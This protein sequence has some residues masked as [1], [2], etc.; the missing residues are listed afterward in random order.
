MNLRSNTT[1]GFLKLLK[2]FFPAGIVSGEDT[3]D[4]PLTAELFNSD[5]MARHS[6]A[7][8]TT[9]VV[10]KKRVKDKLLL[11]LADNEMVLLEV[12][13]LLT[14]S[15]KES[16]LITPAGEW[17]LDNF[18]LLEE[19][20]RTAKKH[21]PKEYSEGLPQLMNG[22][23]A[24]LPR[25]YDIALEIISHS[26]GRID[27][28][29]LNNFVGAYQTVTPFFLGE[30][31]AVPIMLRL[32]L[33]ENLRRVCGQ[34]AIDRINRFLADYWAKRM[35]TA[36]ENEPKSLVLEIADMAR[37]NPPVDRAFV[38]EFTR[39]LRGKGRLLAQPLIWVEE[40]LAEAGQTSNELVQSENQK[41]AAD[42]VSVSNSIGSLRLL[43]D[44]DWK[45]F[46]ENNSVVEHKLLEDGIYALMDFS[47]RDHYRHVVEHI[48]KKSKLQ[49][50]EVAQIA[51]DLTKESAAKN[52]DDDRT[53]HLGYF[54]ISDGLP[55][56]E[57]RAKMHLN[58][59][60]RIERVLAGFPLTLYLGAILLISLSI[61]S[62]IVYKAY[63]DGNSI[64]LIIAFAIISLICASQLAVALVN[65]FTTLIAGPGLLPRMD[66]SI[67]IPKDSKTMVVIPTMLTGTDEIDDLVEALEVRFLANR[68]ENLHFALLTDF[69][70]AHERE[71]PEDEPLLQ[72]AVQK[73]TELNSKY[74][75]EKEDLFFLFQRPRKWN[76]GDNIWMGY[77][78]KRGKLGDLNGFF[79]GNSKDCFS[80]ILGDQDI[81]PQ[82][83]YVI[84]LDSDT[85]LPRESA[86]KI[87]GTMAHPL[88]RAVYSETKRRVVE[89]YGILQPRVS[90]S[91]PGTDST[92]FARMNG[93]EPG[94][95]PYTRATSDVYQDLFAE[96]SFIGKGIYEVDIF[97]KV[98]KGQFPENRI[99]SHDLLEGCYV[100]AGLLSDVQ[101]YEKHPIR[102]NAD[103]QR[104]SRWIRGDWQIAAWFLPFVPGGDKHWHRNPLSALSRWKIFDNIRRSLVPLAFT[105][106][107]LL[108]WTIKDFDAAWTLIIT[109]LIIFPVVLSSVWDLMRK[110]KDLILS[111][112]II[113]SGRS[114]GN[115]A[116][117][118]LFTMICLPYEAYK[119]VD[120]I[121]RVSW[122]MLFSHKHLLDWVT[123]GKIERTKTKGLV[124]SYLD[125]WIEPLV[126]V[127][128]F[129]C[130]IVLSQNTLRS[131]SPILLLWLIAPFI[132]W[133]VSKP[134]ARQTAKLS[135]TAIIYL[136]KLSRKTWSFFE[137]F[138]T[139]IENWLPPDNFQEIP[140]PVIAH[141]TSPTNMGLSLL[142]NLAAYD[143]GYLTTSEFM[144]RTTGAL[145]TMQKMERFKGHFYNW[146]DTLSLAP[147]FPRYIST[148]DSGN[149]A[150]H[151]LTL[152]QGILAMLNQPVIGPQVLKGLRDTLYVLIDVADKSDLIPLNKFKTD[153][154][155]L[156]IVEPDSLPEMYKCLQ[157]LQSNFKFIQNGLNAQPQTEKYRWAAALAR[158][159]QKHVD[160]IQELAPWL[161]LKEAPSGLRFISTLHC[162]PGLNELLSYCADVEVE[163]QQQQNSHN[164]MAQ[165]E[166][167]QAFQLSVTS[168]TASV[169]QKIASLNALALQCIG[170]SELDYDF[171]YSRTKKLLSIGYNVEEHRPDISFYDLLGSEAR[172]STFV[173]IAQGK[174]PQESWFSLGRLL[175]NAGGR[176]ILLSWSGSMFEY[177]MPLLIMPSYENTLLSQTD[178]A[179]VARQIDYGKIRNVPW[180]ISESCY[181]TFDAALSYQ[182][183]AFGVPG[184][185]LKRGL[186]EDLVIAPYA[187]AL[188]LMLKPEHA[189]ENL[190][191]MSDSGF[192][193]K[194][195]FYE[196]IDYTPSRLT[197]GQT[198]AVVQSYMAHHQG[199]S[200]L[201][202]A[203]LLLNQPMQKRFTAEPQFQATLLLLQERIPK[204]TSLFAHTS[205]I[206]E[207]VITINEPHARIITSP[208]TTVPEVQLLSNGKYHVMV[209]NSGGGYS[210]W[211]DIAVTRWREDATRDNWGTFCYIR[212]LDNGTYWSTSFQPT[213][214]K[215]EN[216]EMAF[217]QGRADFKSSKNKLDIHT[218]IVVSPE[219]DIEMRR[220]HICNNS[221]KVRT[222]DITSYAEVVIAPAAADTTHPA[223]SNLF[224][225]T[226]IL[227]HKNA[228]ICTRRP[229]SVNE[230]QPWMLHLMNIHGK[231]TA[232]VSYETDRME[233][234]G[235]GNTAAN[236]QAMRAGGLLSGSQGSVLDPIVAIRHKIVLEPDETIVIDVITGMGETRD[237]CQML[238]DKYQDKHHKD[239]V[240]E[241]AWTHNQVVLRQINA[242]ESE[243][244]LYTRLANSVLF[245]NP[246]LRAE[247]G[248]LIRNHKGQA[249]LWPYS[250]SGDLPV[251]LLKIEEPTAIDLV[252]QLIAAHTF[253]RLKGLS[254]D[255]IIWNDSHDGYR[256]VLQNQ[257][258]GLIGAQLIDKPGGIFIRNSEQISNEDR[259]LFQTVA[260]VIINSNGGSL[261]DHI[262]R[263][264]FPKAVIQNLV[265]TQAY[266]PSSSPV[267]LPAGLVLFNGTGGFSTDG[268]EYVISS[269]SEKRTPA[270]WVN[271]IANPGFGTVISES[272]QSY[273]WHENAH[274]LR[275]T[276]WEN[277]AVSDLG[278]EVFYLRD[279]ETG[280]FWSPT[281]LPVSSSTAYI[282]RHG[283]G[284]SVFEHEEAGIY[285]EMW[286]YVDTEAA[287]KFTAIKLKNKSGKPRRITVTG[288]TEWVLGEMRG[289]TAMHIATEQDPETGALFARNPYNT[290][291]G[292]RVAFF[293]TDG[294]NETFTADR[295]EFIGRNSSLKRPAAMLRTKLSGKIG[296]GLDPCAAIQVTIELS[297]GRE[298]EII[299]KL[300]EGTD[301]QD[302]ANLVRK[303]KGTENAHEALNR[304]VSYWKQSVEALQV[305]TPDKSVDLL[306][307]GW[308]TYQTL[309]CRLWARSGFYQSGGAFGFRDQLQDVI[310]LIHTAPQL[311]RKHIL[312]AASHQFNE[313]DVLHWWH[314]PMGK[315]V[316]TRCSDDYLWLPFVTSG[317]I[318]R[319]GDT[320]ILDEW[321]PFLDGRLLNPGED[322]YYDLFNKS[323]RTAILYNHCVRAIKHGLNFGSHGLPLMGDGDWNDGMD[324]VG[325]QG[326]GE[327]VWLAFFLYDILIKFIPLAN[328]HNDPDF[329]KEC[330]D[331]AV[332]LKEN[333]EKNAW[334]GQW[335]RRAY[336]DDGTPLGSSTNEECQI[337]SLTQSWSVLSGAGLHDRTETGMESAYQRL[338]KEKEG[339]IQLL[340]PAFDKSAMEP[341]YIKGYVPGVRENGGQYTQAA[342]WLLMAFARSGKNKRAWDLLDMINPI[343]HS[344]SQTGIAQY[345]VE[346]YVMAA[347]VYALAPHIGR[348]GWTWYTGSAGWTYQLI[349]ESL[350]GL[351]REG[352]KLIFEPCIPPE[353]ETFKAVYRHNTAHYNIIFIQKDGTG[354]PIVKLDNTGQKGNAIELADDGAGHT[355]EVVLFRN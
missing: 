214:Q 239:R 97:E 126:S 333:I 79:R 324:A 18:Y 48:A 93:N 272:G 125:M 184:L 308:L 273:T 320:G 258:S 223:F 341:G 64:G 234:I 245:V 104:R 151:L 174:L 349:T 278:G 307:N 40:R 72:W 247:P 231:N 91:M 4:E 198:S 283:F 92:F 211:K 337:D 262:N 116:I 39:Q 71:L 175:T 9:H 342:I 276:P 160:E 321:A 127:I 35:I 43:G 157:L 31:W 113:V 13:N 83:K 255:L 253:W 114:A 227:E 168:T 325:R 218:E 345:K 226:E 123:S 58:F 326:K 293:D 69:T 37:S 207:N 50:S 124:N 291:F 144:E 117:T 122:R 317:Y 80:Y 263:K 46:V 15:V 6:I 327:S 224:V 306:V 1:E 177:L 277:D 33:I 3:L 129:I 260:R 17:L 241:M 100:R 335:Y 259:I 193:G 149:L 246:A 340:N 287:I 60:T 331:Q 56:T 158:Q 138:V 195:G 66:F 189:Y 136:Q 27:I 99:L 121:I 73:I 318:S 329:A 352:N 235:R 154:E 256:Q 148:V 205:N 130:L 2:L 315:G 169:N 196:A 328:L 161:L 16:Y 302:A 110:P 96:G 206:A 26:E 354:G 233:F 280:H 131:A 240:F 146:Y 295:A 7:L 311:A 294:I 319:T 248:I 348:G 164:T 200:F 332:I 217:S 109:S 45:E 54:L 301:T 163:I 153:L 313:G 143:F 180:G 178:E 101:L 28:E 95:D 215:M 63:M 165:S 254:V 203:Y 238:I 118:T 166:W 167:L 135:D 133:W 10:S 192:E 115:A 90:V 141:R 264:P 12:R 289:K 304:T 351:N 88:N 134:L 20:I 68:D 353:W 271:V 42:Q 252:K 5:Q 266:I 94:I 212:D 34:I 102:Y 202:M 232:E 236:P 250:I 274:E 51:I 222:I 210:R 32:A 128:V 85:Q 286:V 230:R 336:F 24:G 182:Y 152:R 275:L 61:C 265:P 62:L 150:G 112:H 142:A 19:Q 120:V 59:I 139:E 44:I 84:T 155:K 8:A 75:R 296:V 132:T 181:N 38:A 339:L 290:D 209:T 269:D 338:V 47:T 299:F 267:L 106:F 343:N 242:T 284:Y 350:L 14:Q 190:Q 159:I 53:A 249:G 55:Q 251:V 316:R 98:L 52:G 201:S 145:N 67:G 312:L 297:E 137:Q 21:L 344:A 199:M 185:G 78:R 261:T 29:S 194:Y 108:G 86:W 322:S 310:S 268:R 309:S 303:F 25:V 74:G 11:R 281:P 305:E 41:Q 334:D 162:M 87:I 23:S 292:G 228:I 179:A 216:L 323:D 22:P 176:P 107:V 288:Y 229:K 188:A 57:K 171:L 204:A 279:E 355:V 213:L 70:D 298:K 346:P 330:S 270:P 237:I 77:E 219:D 49:E 172:L 285:S 243:A 147:L 105:L 111:H 187:S 191:L 244:Q 314:P 76:A 36:A 220:T 221:G 82:I 65:F 89:G 81:L 197:R 208:H 119:N 103:M 347:D 257:I 140:S 186:G 225:Q 300:G 170:L 30:L 183:H 173:G 282:T 156:S